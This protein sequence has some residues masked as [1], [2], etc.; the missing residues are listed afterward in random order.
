MTRSFATYYRDCGLSVIPLRPRDK[1][2]A[3]ASWK[4]Y[5]ERLPT[6]A[7]IE[8][9][10]PEGTEHGIGIVCG[11]VSG[12][13]A[14]D[15]DAHL[16]ARSFL[17]LN[18]EFEDGTVR[19]ATA[20]GQH[21]W[22]QVRERVATL[23]IEEIGLDVKGQ[24]SYV[25]APPSVHPS[26]KPYKFANDADTLIGIEDFNGWLR[27]VLAG[28][29]VEWQ[30]AG[31]NGQRQLLDVD[32][33]LADLDE[34]N[35]NESFAKVIGKL[36]RASLSAQDI[37]SLLQPHAERVDFDLTELREEVEGI[38]GRY[39]ASKD[40]DK[41][42]LSPFQAE[43]L[44]GLLDE[45]DEA[46]EALI[47]DGGD[48]AVLT[49]DGKG[50]VAGPT[51]VGKTNLLLRLSRCLCEGSPFLGLPIPQ[52][53][54]VLYLALEGS[55]RGTR[56][57]LRKVWTDADAD[58]FQRFTL[59]FISLN[60]ANG[61]DLQRLEA[62]LEAAQPEVLIIDPLRNAH[63]WDENA[64]QE[65]A[66][67]TSIL[68][69][70]IARYHLAIICAHHDRK[71][72]P[73]VRR[74]AG[75]DR[76]RGS[77]ALT[78][79]LQFCLSLD[80]DPKTPDTLVAEWTK[81]RDAEVALAPLVLDFDRDTLDFL[82]SERAPGGKVS[83]EAVL[84]AVAEN[85]G[86]FRGPE[87]LAAFQEGSGASQRSIRERLRELVKGGKLIQYEADPKSRALTYA[88]P[89]KEAEEALA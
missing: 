62:L 32:T 42:T 71:R 28:L 11:G 56:R 15:F 68:D 44:E 25:V 2:P 30:P 36:H 70:L 33:L 9:W 66:R 55:R 27:G 67:L 12:M 47:G 61:D 54:R 49:R 29:G 5:Q 18:P 72:P 6:D 23:R 59:A 77:T 87:L 35:R 14:L 20:R 1:R 88:L 85:G 40:G 3:L 41:P 58:T 13:V 76:V 83:E 78:G 84:N 73:F 38:C 63:P 21:I 69:A 24:G 65:A 22:V 17:D 34:G 50:F 64:S 4:E 80:P 74:D 46:L 10:W 19:V 31:G 60:L 53:C 79:W 48:G 39:P 43:T 81:T 7:E 51:G 89:N 57:R 52:P 8:E 82:V 45:T 75:T 16:T 37:L 86:S 26:G